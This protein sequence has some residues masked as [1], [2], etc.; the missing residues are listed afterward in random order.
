ML[1]EKNN[2]YA[3]RA[4]QVVNAG[5]DLIA[6]NDSAFTRAAEEFGFKAGKQDRRQRDVKA[7]GQ[8]VFIARGPLKGYKGKIVFAD[9]VSATI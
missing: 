9:E 7:T 6:Q 5:H 4:S 8:T 3:I 1:R 2:F